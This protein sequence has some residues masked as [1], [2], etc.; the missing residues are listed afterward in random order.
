MYHIVYG[1]I[2]GAAAALAVTLL[3]RFGRVLTLP[4]AMIAALVTVVLFDA[5]FV[6][7]K[8]KVE[9]FAWLAL[10]LALIS[11]AV[12]TLMAFIPIGQHVEDDNRELPG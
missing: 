2:I 3:G 5:G 7:F 9:P 11:F 4:G 10:V 6:L 12:H 1:I 8:P